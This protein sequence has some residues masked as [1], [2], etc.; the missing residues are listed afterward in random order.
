L[1]TPANRTKNFSRNS[2]DS[3]KA[4]L[5]LTWIISFMC[6]VALGC[7]HRGGAKAAA[8]VHR[9]KTRRSL[10]TGNFRSFAEYRVSACTISGSISR[11]DKAA[12]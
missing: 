11:I 1:H 4:R 10:F 6:A 12:M 3:G 5:I 7:A 8:V 9:E 2:C